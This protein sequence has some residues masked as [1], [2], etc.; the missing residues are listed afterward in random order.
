MSHFEPSAAGYLFPLF[1]TSGLFL[2]CFIPAPPVPLCRRPSE[3]MLITAARP[4]GSV[5]VFTAVG[6]RGSNFCTSKWIDV[7]LFH[8]R[9]LIFLA[10]LRDAECCFKRELS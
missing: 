2:R 10:Q 3:S 5:D 4:S 1:N 7:Y 9:I 8:R 6:E